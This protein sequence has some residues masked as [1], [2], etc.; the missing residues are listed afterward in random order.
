MNI[1]VIISNPYRA[2][3]RQ[4]VKVHLDTLRSH[5]IFAQVEKLPHNPLQRR[6][7]F[8]K[9]VD[10][11]C[12]FLHKKAL[13]YLNAIWLKKYSKTVVYDFDDAIM[14]NAEH[15]EKYDAK[16]QRAFKRI[17]EISNMMIAGCPYLAEQAK[18]FNPNV[19]VLP[20]G[21]DTKIFNSNYSIPKD[22]KI[23]LF[24]LGVK[25]LYDILKKSSLP[26][27]K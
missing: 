8:K 26:L 14:Y 6:E 10:Y 11:D 17:A 3:F 18:K 12:V 9:A 24:G 2:S 4:R 19:Y 21:L 15:P 22:D 23:D 20:T 16:R 1:L 25:V 5:G 13:N 27:R 7:L